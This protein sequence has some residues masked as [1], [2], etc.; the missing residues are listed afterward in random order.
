MITPEQAIEA[1]LY[2]AANECL[3]YPSQV[4]AFEEADKI[5]A[6]FSQEKGRDA[7]DE[8]NEYS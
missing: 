7:W 3:I 4:A 8:L 1:K 2:L 5:K 6:Q